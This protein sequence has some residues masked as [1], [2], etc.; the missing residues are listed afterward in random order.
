MPDT[1]GRWAKYRGEITSRIDD[2]TPLFAEVK[3]QKPSGDGWVLGLCPLH[4]DRNPSFRFHPQTGHWGCFAGCGSG[5]VFDY[6]EAVSGKDFK[7][8][9]VEV[10]DQ[11]GVKRPAD[12]KPRPPIDEALV[13][14]WHQNLMADQA[15]RWELQ[16]CR[17]IDDETLSKYAIGWDAKRKRFTIPIR[18]KDGQVVNVRLYSLQKEPKIINYTDGKHRYGSPPRLYGLDELVE[19]KAPQVVLCEGEWDRLLLQQL[20]FVAVTGT[21][22][23][24]TFRQEWVPFFKD[25]EVTILFDV[26]A[27]GREAA[28]KV[29]QALSTNSGISVKIAALALS[30]SKDDNDVTDFCLKHFKT[31]GDIQAVIDQAVRFRQNAGKPSII[32]TDRQM[33][34]L[35]QETWEAVLAANDPPTVFR[36]NGRLAR[37]FD[38]G[39]SLYIED[40][41]DDQ[42]RHL[43]YTTADWYKQG[44]QG[45]KHAKPPRELPRDLLAKP[46][47]DLPSIEGIVTAPVFSSDGDLIDRPGYNPETR[48]WYDK[49]AGFDMPTV[50]DR[51]SKEEIS[52]ARSLLL[53][54]LFV[55]FPF[56]KLSDLAHAVAALLLAFLRLL[57]DG[58]TPIH[59]LE[60]ATP[61]SG[62]SLVAEVVWWIFMGRPCEPTTLT[63]NEDESRKK[64]TALLHRGSPVVVI[65]NLRDGL[66]SGQLAAA[67]TAGVW[68][69]RILG[70]TAMVEFFNR[71]VWLITSNNPDVSTELTRRCVRIRIDSGLERPWLRTDFKH[72]LLTAWVRRHRGELVWSCL[73]LIQAWFAAGRP[74]GETVLGSFENWSETMGGILQV[75][76]INGF[77]EDTE[78]FY[79]AADTEGAEWRAF[80]A[81]WEEEHGQQPVAVADLLQMAENHDLLGFAITGKTVQAQKVRLGIAL[82][83]QRDRRFGDQRIV[84]EMNLHTKAKEYRLVVAQPS[85]LPVGSEA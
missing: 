83:R 16:R 51:P 60:A 72:P 15:L 70:K 34:D 80:V 46:H 66:R 81:A 29:A 31:A 84:A 2:Y 77:L 78:E 39:S 79:E 85:L 23:A 42:V 75:A 35:V 17:G 56:V 20:G 59:L 36:H 26:D 8:V 7:A 30:G 44:P 63:R 12:Q 38:T 14:G 1:N 19:S 76:G 65:D 69:D 27:E 68:S 24:A 48:F 3:D 55:D 25:K 21:H 6:L 40:M 74:K 62:K 50:P 71:A 9:L 13:R 22:G 10:G 49:P 33:E 57:I 47:P 53:N 11:Y 45:L 43:L 32:V 18:D 73:T 54:D 67:L 52:H 61:G 28:D 82:N 37:I 4:E 64:I 41:T 5:G 58:C